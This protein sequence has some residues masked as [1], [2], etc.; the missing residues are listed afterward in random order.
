M[1]EA[2]TSPL[3]IEVVSKY[4]KARN[5]MTMS[6][7]YEG[8]QT[9]DDNGRGWQ[10][11]QEHDL[12]GW[13]NFMEGRISSKYVEMQRSYY[14]SKVQQSGRKKRTRWSKPEKKT[15]RKSEIKWATSFI[16]NIIR[17]THNQWTWRNEKLHYRRH[18]GAESKFEYEQI[19][20]Q[21]LSKMEMTDP[22]DLLPEDQ[23]ILG[24]DP[25]EIAKTT[26]DGRQAWLANFEAAVAAAGH[27][28]RSRDEL[29]DQD[30]EDGEEPRSNPL[31]PPQDKFGKIIRDGKEW[32]NKIRRKRINRWKQHNFLGKHKIEDY[33]S[34]DSET[35]SH[36][37]SP[38]T[39]SNATN[40]VPPAQSNTTSSAINS[41]RTTAK[42]NKK[43]R[44]QTT[45]NR[46]LG[47]Q[48]NNTQQQRTQQQSNPSSSSETDT[49]PPHA[50]NQQLDMSNPPT[51]RRTQQSL[52]FSSE[53]SQIYKRRRL[54]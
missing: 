17:I 8:P 11:V 31:R 38:P 19:M 7:L 37:D 18:P 41:R 44:T 21:I 24:V 30:D 34:D 28:K 53:G 1:K 42:G 3:I 29:D 20:N 33:L 47:N 40:I 36:P 22:E 12:L 35:E 49:N 46:W 14:M 27:A 23:Y 32:R 9:D 43:I 52:S 5:T 10:L 25:E 39:D 2:D 16:E 50:E 48:T 45:M 15:Y 4:L 26:P 6:E 51:R 54:K 13:Q